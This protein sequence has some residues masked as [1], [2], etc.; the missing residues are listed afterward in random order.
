MEKLLRQKSL[1]HLRMSLPL[2]PSRRCCLRALLPCHVHLLENLMIKW[3]AFTAVNI[4]GR[5]FKYSRTATLSKILFGL[6][7]QQ[8]HIFLQPQPPTLEDQGLIS[9]WPFLDRLLSPQLRALSTYP[10]R[11]RGYQLGVCRVVK[12]VTVQSLLRI[13]VKHGSHIMFG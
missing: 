11:G 8:S 5:W 3:R 13:W 1:W 7:M 12:L 9:E 2:F 6:K 4:S 10:L